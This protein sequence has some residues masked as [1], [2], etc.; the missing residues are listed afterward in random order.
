MALKAL[1]LF[2][3]YIFNNLLAPEKD[4]KVEEIG[5]MKLSINTIY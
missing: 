2:L 4:K 1:V 5:K 3:N